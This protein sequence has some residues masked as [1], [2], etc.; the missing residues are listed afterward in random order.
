MKLHKFRLATCLVCIYTFKKSL[1]SP[2]WINHI[3]ACYGPEC[4]YF[5]DC[6]VNYRPDL[7]LIENSGYLYFLCRY[8][9]GEYFKFL[10][11]VNFLIW[12][13]GIFYRPTCKIQNR[14][15]GILNFYIS[16]SF[17]LI[18]IFH[19]EHLVFVDLDILGACR[20]PSLKH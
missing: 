8:F 12:K 15:L 2:F 18:F 13:H 1:Y 19:F 9:P 3:C 7:W 10:A 4:K 11:L 16:L 20:H 6:C 17:I 5:T 14:K